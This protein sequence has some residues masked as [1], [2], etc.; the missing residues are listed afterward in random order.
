MTGNPQR[1][2]TSMIHERYSEQLNVTDEKINE[3][4]NNFMCYIEEIKLQMSFGLNSIKNYKNLFEFSANYDIN[5]CCK[6]DNQRIDNEKFERIKPI[7]DC[8]EK[9]LRENFAIKK[10]IKKN[11]AVLKIV[12][13]LVPLFVGLKKRMKIPDMNNLLPIITGD[14]VHTERELPP[15]MLSP[16]FRSKTFT[17]SNFNKTQSN[18]NASD[19]K[20]D[21]GTG[22]T[23]DVYFNLHG[24]IQFEIETCPVNSNCTEL[25]DL[26]WLFMSS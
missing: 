3:E 22:N 7:L 17:Y 20:K 9:F 1:A 14:E 2:Y 12:G 15:L 24:G 5:T 21:A 19:N 11:L 10:E 26:R 6:A 4:I 23:K 8:H 16:E 13:F 18:H 25:V